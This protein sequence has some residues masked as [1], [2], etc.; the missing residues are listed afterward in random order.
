MII[1][2]DISH[3]SGTWLNVDFIAAARGEG[4]EGRAAY[5]NFSELPKRPYTRRET[6]SE[7]V[8]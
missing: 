6:H 2:D 7:V 3:E 4:V 1:R 5:E 8:N